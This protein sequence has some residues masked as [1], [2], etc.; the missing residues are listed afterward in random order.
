M[1]KNKFKIGDRVVALT[2]VNVADYIPVTAG[3]TGTVIEDSKYPWVMWD[4]LKDYWASRE[5]Y[6]ELI[7]E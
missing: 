4:D 1:E 5:E 2:N 3:M 6:L 7:V